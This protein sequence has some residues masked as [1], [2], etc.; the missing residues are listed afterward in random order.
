MSKASLFSGIF[1][2]LVCISVWLIIALFLTENE[3]NPIQ[4]ALDE[5]FSKLEEF[6]LQQK[7]ATY[8]GRKFNETDESLKNYV[9]EIR[10]F[11]P[12]IITTTLVISVM[13]ALSTILM[14]IT[15]KFQLSP[16]LG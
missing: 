4:D 10:A 9:E 5:F 13:Y 2:L 6:F 12:S 8:Q 7:N 11:C 3:F 16:G 1:S 15:I 14:M